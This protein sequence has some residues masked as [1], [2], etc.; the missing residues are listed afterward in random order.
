MY[1]DDLASMNPRHAR[2]WNSADF[3]HPLGRHDATYAALIPE[4]IRR[5]VDPDAVNRGALD[6]HHAALFRDAGEAEAVAVGFEDGPFG[7]V[8]IPSEFVK[9]IGKGEGFQVFSDPRG[10]GSS[11]WHVW[12]DEGSSVWDLNSDDQ[13]GPALSPTPRILPLA[14]PFFSG[15]IRLC[16]VQLAIIQ[17]IYP[18][19]KAVRLVV[20]GEKWFFVFHGGAPSHRRIRAQK[21]RRN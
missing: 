17:K 18:L 10:I 1:F 9:K 11:G 7:V 6:H 12:L 2:R 3:R 8:T 19:K 14:V 4:T 13:C 21:T 15:W 20:E 5:I 16:I